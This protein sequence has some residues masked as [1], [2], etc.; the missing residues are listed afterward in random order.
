MQWCGLNYN[1]NGI[2]FSYGYGSGGTFIIPLSTGKK[3]LAVAV[4]TVYALRPWACA[5]YN[6]RVTDTVYAVAARYGLL[7]QCM[8]SQQDSRGLYMLEPTGYGL[9]VYAAAGYRIRV[10]YAVTAGYRLRVSR[11][12][13]MLLPTGNG[14]LRPCKPKQQRPCMPQRKVTGNGLRI[15]R[16]CRSGL[17]RPCMPLQRVSRLKSCMPK[18]YMPQRVI[19]TVYDVAALTH[20]LSRSCMPLQRVSRGLYMLEPSGLLRPCMP[21][22]GFEHVLTQRV[23]DTVYALVIETGFVHALTQRFIDTVW[24]KR[25]SR[26]LYM[27][28]PSVLFV[29][30]LTQQRPCMPQRKVTGNGLRINRVCRSGLSRPCMPLQRVS[31][32][33]SCMP[34]HYMP[35]RVIETVYDVAALTHRLSRS[36]MPLQRVSRGLY[37]LEPSGLLRPC[38]P[39]QGFEHVLTQRVIDTVY[40]L[41]IE[42]GFVHALTQRFIDTVWPK[43]VSRGLYMLLPSVLRVIETVYA[44]RPCMPLQVIPFVHALTQRISSMGLTEYAVAVPFMPLQ[45]IPCMPLRRVTGLYGLR[46]MVCICSNPRVTHSSSHHSSS[47]H[48]TSK[49]SKTSGTSEHSHSSSTKSRKY[50]TID[51]DSLNFVYQS[52]NNV[53]LKE[54]RSK[55]ECKLNSSFGFDGNHIWV[56]KGCRGRFNV[57]Y[58][59]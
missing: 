45:V 33:K 12:F 8:P 7:R 36:C 6:P 20:R 32:L 55:S 23:I 38:M 44:L 22:Q 24:P 57:C 50:V 17:S 46:V 21:L 5:F 11:G 15:N 35:Q 9:T 2:R 1:I 26:G 16:V 27:L 19:E 51:C 34:K 13:Y 29:H 25:V 28:L 37:M 52:I 43:R 4:E 53:R 39:L 14:L 49:S 30:A 10:M 18:H 56:N 47:H 59:S 58:N 40:A 48:D 42:T 3:G 31:R 54:Q 41:V